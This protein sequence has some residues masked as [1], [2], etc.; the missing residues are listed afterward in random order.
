MGHSLDSSKGLYRGL[1]GGVLYGGSTIAG[2]K[3]HFRSVGC[4]SRIY[5]NPQSDSSYILL[6]NP[7]V[8]PDLRQGLSPQFPTVWYQVNAPYKIAP[9]YGVNKALVYLQESFVVRI[10]GW[11]IFKL[12]NKHMHLKNKHMHDKRKMGCC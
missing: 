10:T 4:S 3:G 12:K 11:G 6:F 1:Y 5:K 8:S 9:K 2:I 7:S